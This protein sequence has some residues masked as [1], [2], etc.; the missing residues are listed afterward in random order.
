MN[1]TEARHPL[2]DEIAA[3]L[4]SDGPTDANLNA[5]LERTLKHFDCAAG[6]VHVSDGPAGPLRLRAHHG[7]P[8]A[9]LDRARTVPI[10]K[11]MAGLAA[12]WRKPVQVCNLQTDTSG[13]ARP[14][15]RETKMEG[16]IA[17]P[18]LTDGT[19]R[20][21]LGVAKPVAY[22]FSDAESALLLQIAAVI[23]GFLSRPQS[24]ATP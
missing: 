20:G 23:G 21:V 10:G 22:D 12:E 6:T 11:G 24:G 16:S 1:E 8:T 9:V 5:V 7:I 18:M 4:E 19:V 13:V 15:A 3:R 14:T 17:V 2:V